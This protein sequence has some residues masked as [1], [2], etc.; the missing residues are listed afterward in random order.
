MGT[1]SDEEP[2]MA[3]VP[4]E[5]A[6]VVP[7]VTAWLPA[8]GA[9]VEP[10]VTGAVLP[11]GAALLPAVTFVFGKPDIVSSG[12]ELQAINTLQQLTLVSSER[13]ADLMFRLERQ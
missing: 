6:A 11:P 5:P 8:R 4:P 2:A 3:T 12:S 10:A 7:A 1:G 13:A 9:L